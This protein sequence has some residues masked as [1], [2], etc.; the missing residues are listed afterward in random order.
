MYQESTDFIQQ[1][2][3]MTL[4]KKCMLLLNLGEEWIKIL[5]QSSTTNLTQS[6]RVMPP[7]KTKEKERQHLKGIE[8]LTELMNI[9]LDSLE[10]AATREVEGTMSSGH[11]LRHVNMSQYYWHLTECMDIWG[12]LPTT[13]SGAKAEHLLNRMEKVC[14]LDDHYAPL[15]PN[16][17]AYGSVMKAWV[18]TIDTP[19][20]TNGAVEASRVLEHQCDLFSAGFGKHSPPNMHIYNTLMHGYAMRGMVPEAESLLEG[21]ENKSIYAESVEGERIYFTPDVMTYSS[22]INVYS[23]YKG[24]PLKGKSAADRAEDL[25]HR[26]YKKYEE[27]GDS[28]FMPNQITFG[29]GM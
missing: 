23:K 4:S 1:C 20:G 7:T 22:C 24:R 11:F 10:D 3:N 5:K 13:T 19:G 9:L 26:L 16:A 28:K 12:S 18:N 25:L 2:Q 29:T 15:T 14:T 6:P 8:V 27:T 21:L 17:V